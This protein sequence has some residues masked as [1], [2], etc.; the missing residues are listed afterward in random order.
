MTEN[1]IMTVEECAEMLNCNP[2]TVRESIDNKTFP[3]GVCFKSKSGTKIYKISR[4]A[5]NKWINGEGD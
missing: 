2:R 3:F 4:R 1:L 5:I